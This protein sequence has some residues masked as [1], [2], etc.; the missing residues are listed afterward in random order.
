[1]Y[2]E[3]S[4]PEVK[5]EEG[6]PVGAKIARQ[7]CWTKVGC[8]N[9][10]KKNCLLS[11]PVVNSLLFLKSVSLKYR[12]L[13]FHKFNCIEG[14]ERHSNRKKGNLVCKIN[15]NQSNFQNPLLLYL[16]RMPHQK[17]Q[18][19]SLRESASSWAD[20]RRFMSQQDLWLDWRKSKGIH[21][22][23]RRSGAGAKAS[24]VGRSNWAVNRSPAGAVDKKRR[25]E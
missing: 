18:W 22:E 24:A 4:Y 11:P 9:R 10:L 17:Q 16:R 2:S 8:I 3:R 19:R 21:T 13:V 25:V 1:M 6:P 23:N 15:S 20:R 14:K 5:K 7:R 12:S